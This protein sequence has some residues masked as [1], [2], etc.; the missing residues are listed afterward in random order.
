MFWGLLRKKNCDKK[1]FSENFEF[2]NPTFSTKEKIIRGVCYGHPGETEMYK[3]E[4]NGE[5]V[6]TL[7]Y[8]SYQKNNNGVKTGKVAILTYTPNSNSFKTLNVLKSVPAEYK[9]IEGFD[10]FTGNGYD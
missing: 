7:E 6:D 9:K 5:K 4:W 1:A 2:V 8:V 3:Y 10:W